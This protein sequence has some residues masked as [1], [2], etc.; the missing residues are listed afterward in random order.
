MWGT[1][2]VRARRGS[3]VD[4]TKGWSIS[5]IAFPYSRSHG[6]VRSMH[7]LRIAI[8]TSMLMG[9]V[10][11]PAS[12]AISGPSGIVTT[13]D[14][15][16][17]SVTDLG[18]FPSWGQW[19]V[20]TPST[21]GAPMCVESYPVNIPTAITGDGRYFVEYWPGDSFTWTNLGSTIPG[22]T[23]CDYISGTPHTPH[24][25][26]VDTT[27][28]VPSILAGINGAKV[29]LS[30]RATDTV[31]SFKLL[32]KFTWDTVPPSNS[33]QTNATRDIASSNTCTGPI[34]LIDEVPAGVY[35]CDAASAGP[36]WTVP[37]PG[38][39]TFSLTTVD[40]A[41]NS[42]SVT[43]TVSVPTWPG[44]VAPTTPGP[45]QPIKTPEPAQPTKGQI[46]AAA[47]RDL[48]V[49]KSRIVRMGIRGL[50]RNGSFAAQVR[51]LARGTS[52]VTLFA[53][54]RTPTGPRK[55]R[56]G[57]A[58]RAFSA[59]GNA[60][61]RVTMTAFGRRLLRT[62]PRIRLTLLVSFSSTAGSANR[63]ASIVLVR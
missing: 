28:P 40:Q 52:K 5:P 49:T 29:T 56:I 6:I 22:A 33:V 9:V 58:T 53:T 62:A 11:H 35:P 47:A 48:A 38:D 13:H 43:K 19:R 10:A 26:W 21:I 41:G 12:A 2:S 23:R 51:P 36:T 45:T 59:A 37:M 7:F 54:I 63:V 46:G 61:L 57:V 34:D 3:R 20:T 14:P 42:A 4:P 1:R 8:V 18:E 60:N 16:V 17:W 50:S 39:Y 30:G 44:Y 31:T 15:V 25:L 27:P 32:S 24:E 55:V